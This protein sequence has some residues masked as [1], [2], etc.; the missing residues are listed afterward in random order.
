MKPRV[1]IIDDEQNILV[2]LTLALRSEFAVETALT[3]GEGVEKFRVGNF[4]LVLLDLM[5][6]D[7]DG[8]QVLEQLKAISDKAAFIV[9]TAFGSIRSSVD[10]VKKGAFTYLTKP[11]DL[12]ELKIYMYQALQYQ[13]L[14]KTIANLTNELNA[15]YDNYG[16]QGNSEAIGRVRNMISR[17]KDVDASVVITGESGTGKELIARALHYSGA[18]KMGKFVAINCAAIP[19]GL[20]ESEFFGHKKGSFTGAVQD[21]VGKFEQADKGTLFLDEIGDMPLSLQI[22]FLRSLQEQVITPIG[23]ATPIHVDVRV[24]AATNRNLTELIRQ[25]QFREDLYYRLHVMEICVPPL[26]E[27]PEDIMV[28][29][30]H[31]LSQY[32]KTHHTLPFE[33]APDALDALNHY[34]Y[35]GNVRQLFNVLEYAALMCTDQR[36]TAA[37]LPME[38]LQ[39]SHLSGAEAA[40]QEPRLSDLIVDMP[41]RDLERMA[42]LATL[43]KNN[44]QK[45]ITAQ[46]LG[47]S[48]RNLRYKLQE[49]GSF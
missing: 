12:E 15:K 19:E 10:A 13:E 4:Q 20:L 3:A 26:R 14:N 23:S 36:I 17:L 49:Y 44:G 28:L 22:K 46:K 45:K 6:N 30:G 27:R 47:I 8:L 5:I 2:S 43:E 7:D 48:D 16:I 39:E 34:S 18:R 37:N 25:G 24:I 42:I 29:C 31:F 41:L 40:V 33:L 35:P 21:I 38:V 11:V 9:I 32:A 1:L